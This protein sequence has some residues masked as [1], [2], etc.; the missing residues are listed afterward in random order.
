MFNM[1]ILQDRYCNT[2]RVYV[3]P[4]PPS[5]LTPAAVD[6]DTYIISQQMYIIK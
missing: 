1:F 4:P 3:I 2:V 5:G 6:N